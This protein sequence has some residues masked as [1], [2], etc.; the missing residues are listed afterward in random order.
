MINRNTMH[1][2]K[3]PQI[4]VG[5]LKEYLA[6]IPDDV[7]I[8]VGIGSEREPLHYLLNCGGDLVLHPD[9]YMQDAKENNIQTIMSFNIKK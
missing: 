9:C 8:C 2:D 7:K 5:R 4:T 6:C 3:G 1:Y